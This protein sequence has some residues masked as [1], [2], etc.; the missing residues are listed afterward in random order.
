VRELPTSLTSQSE[1]E[2]GAAFLETLGSDGVDVALAQDDVVVAPDLDL[3]AVLGVEEDLI[4]G[5]ERA[6]VGAGGDDLGSG[7]P[8]GHL[9]RGRD[10]DAARRP[11]FAVGLEPHEDAVVEHLDREPFSAGVAGHPADRTGPDD[12]AIRPDGR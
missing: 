10:Q 9:G 12:G 7:Q 8:L 1:V 4:A 2:A 11:P 6:D 5:L 3:V